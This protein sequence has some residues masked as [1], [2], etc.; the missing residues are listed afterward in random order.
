M[1]NLTVDTARTTNTDLATLD[2]AVQDKI[3]DTVA[4]SK[5]ANTLR[6]YQSDMRQVAKYL[7]DTGHTDLV[8]R[9]GTTWQ[10]VKPLPAALVAAYLVERSEQGTAL[11]SLQRHAA[12]ISKWH[13]V[14]ASSQP[15]VA[16]PCRSQLV[17]D[18]VAGLRKQNMRQPDRAAPLLPNQLAEIVN[19]LDLD[20]LMG[21]RDRAIVLVGWCA[22]L[23]RSELANLK[24]SQV[25]FVPEGLQ[26]TV[27]RGKADTAGFGEQVGVPYQDNAALCPVRAM[28]AW[29][30][31]NW[32]DT[33]SD[34]AVFTRV[35]HH[36]NRTQLPLSGQ[37]VG[38]IVKACAARIGLD[39]Y[40]GHSLRAGLATA[41]THAGIPEHQVMNTTRHRSQ[42]VFR[43]YV[44]E[45][46]LFTKAASRGLLS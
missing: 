43:G 27:M 14:V 17:R 6:A 33:Q 39:N 16:N 13:Q 40:T 15:G 22:A 10:L 23:R 21:V 5:A 7:A 26:I 31:S 2:Q 34:Q 20:T 38:N 30:K 11:T 45:A 42:A 28:V 35:I 9:I 12:S 24:W 29:A 44:R 1:T 41:A 46:E 4:A 8:R 37:A 36:N 19:A 18:T 3:T 32:S 25:R